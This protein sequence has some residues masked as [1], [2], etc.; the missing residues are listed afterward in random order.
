[1]RDRDDAL[2]GALLGTAVGDALGLPY[3]GLRAETIARLAPDW[4]VPF[5][6]GVV[7]DDT[8]QT[9]LVVEALRESGGDRLAFRSALARGLGRWFRA[10]PPGVGLG[11]ARA[12]LKLSVGVPPTHSGV[13]SAG[14]GPAMR[15]AP[16]GLLAPDDDLDAWVEE[17]SRI[18]HTDPRAIDGARIVAHAARGGRSVASTLPELA[19]DPAFSEAMRVAVSGP[20]NDVVEHLGIRGFVSG[21]VVHA[22]P[23]AIAVWLTHDDLRDTVEAAVRLGGDTDTV[24]AIAGALTGASRG[25]AR[26]EPDLAALPALPEGIDG[27][28]GRAPAV[29]SG[30]ALIRNLGL[31][32]RFVAHTLTRRLRVR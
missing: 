30:A 29:G 8:E 32:P 14:N 1:M 23:V 24:G 2:H 3:E 10:L 13:W 19:R 5:D 11:T 21:F 16:L 31:L 27:L 28:P 9:W 17:A 4:L 6:D 18:T 12:L 22:V 20:P 26:I 25:A 7:S 15:A